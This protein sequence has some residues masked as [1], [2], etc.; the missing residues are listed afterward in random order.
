MESDSAIGEPKRTIP[1][2]TMP[3]E[4]SPRAVPLGPGGTA[5]LDQIELDAIQ[6]A[7][8]E[9]AGN[10][11]AAARRLGI[12]RNTLYRKLGRF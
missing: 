6:R 12:S 7:L 11:S 9:S 8:N 3:S 5:R 10:V 4:A 1:A 2:A